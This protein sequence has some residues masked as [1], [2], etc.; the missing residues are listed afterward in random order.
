MNF[1]GAENKY[2]YNKGSELQNKEFFDGSGLEWY[3]THFRQLDVQ[4]G[5]WNQIDP[6]PNYDESLYA[7]MCNNSL[8]HN[9]PL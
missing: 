3:D 9:D 7:S 5:R 4:I 2:K 1:G 6:K 8:L